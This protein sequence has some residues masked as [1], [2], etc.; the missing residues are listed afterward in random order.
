MGKL[1]EKMEKKMEKKGWYFRNCD[2]IIKSSM[3]KRR[4]AETSEKPVQRT[5]IDFSVVSASFHT[6]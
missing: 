5:G 6:E 2:D 4:A 3:Q 1:P